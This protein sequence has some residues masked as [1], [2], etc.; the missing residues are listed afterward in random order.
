MPVTLTAEAARCIRDGARE[1]G[2]EE[3][4]L[5]VAGRL[6]AGEPVFGLGFDER[7]EQDTEHES[8]GVTV[9]VSPPSLALVDDLIIDYVEL[10][11]GRSQFVFVHGAQAQG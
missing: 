10:A 2:L 9:L 1:Q 5:R 7:R 11:P 8:D 4:L 3:V 6:E